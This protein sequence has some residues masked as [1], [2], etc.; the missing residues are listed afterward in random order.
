MNRVKKHL[1]YCG[2]ALGQGSDT[3]V[4]PLSQRLCSIGIC[5]IILNRGMLGQGPDPCPSTPL[6]RRRYSYGRV[7]S[8]TVTIGVVQKNIVYGEQLCEEQSDFSAGDGFAQGDK[9]ACIE[10]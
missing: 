9:T 2:S 8:V 5:S 3:G 1:I 6:S 4:R 10:T 7:F